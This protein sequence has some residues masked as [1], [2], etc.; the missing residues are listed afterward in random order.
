[1]N[2]FKE[3]NNAINEISLL[4][5]F[6][7]ILTFCAQNSIYTDSLWGIFSFGDEIYKIIR[8]Y[9]VLS[10]VL[11]FI[12]AFIL[13]IFSTVIFHITALICSERDIKIGLLLKASTICLLI[14]LIAEFSI[15]IILY[16]Q[17][18]SVKN[19]YE[20][21]YL[22]LKS[23]YCYFK[24]IM[25]SSYIFYLLGMVIFIKNIYRLNLRLS[26]ISVLLPILSIGIIYLLFK[27]I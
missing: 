1:M 11:S 18:V 26:I 17:N 7:I 24:Y 12:S 25:W 5:L 23:P 20:L 15:N 8:P 10:S 9:R 19:T 2:R 13:W 22:F 6:I 16:F 3:V 27:H 14:P 21:K 4:P